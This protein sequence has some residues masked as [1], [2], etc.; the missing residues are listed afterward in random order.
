MLFTNTT[1]EINK[2]TTKEGKEL[3]S[4]ELFNIYNSKYFTQVDK[5]MTE[6]IL[7]VK[8]NVTHRYLDIE[9]SE[10][11]FMFKNTKS[12]KL[13]IVLDMLDYKQFAVKETKIEVGAKSEFAFNLVHEFKLKNRL[14]T[15][16]TVSIFDVT[17]NGFGILRLTTTSGRVKYLIVKDKIARIFT[18][19]GAETFLKDNGIEFDLDGEWL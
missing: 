3:R 1:L 13:T 14:N 2:I 16:W 15:T 18:L 6:K 7:F 17:E 8:D 19:K 9:K 11:G 4:L 12:D 10:K 5:D